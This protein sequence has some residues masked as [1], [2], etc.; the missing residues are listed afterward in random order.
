MALFNCKLPID[1]QVRG[2]TSKFQSKKRKQK[3]VNYNLESLLT[4]KIS[5]K[6]IGAQ[7]CFYISLVAFKALLS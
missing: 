7:H 4:K 2:W 6:D 1:Q 3:N 5:H